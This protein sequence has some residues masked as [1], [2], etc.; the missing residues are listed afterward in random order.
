MPPACAL[1]PPDSGTAGPAMMAVTFAKYAFLL[2]SGGRK[3]KMYGDT[4]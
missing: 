1:L 3:D 4:G 2:P